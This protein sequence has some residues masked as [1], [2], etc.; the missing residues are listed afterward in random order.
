MLM[1]KD[2]CSARQ[3]MSHRLVDSHREAGGFGLPAHEAHPVAPE[4]SLAY[5]RGP[6][7]ADTSSQS[8][9]S[10]PAV[11]AE[12]RQCAQRPTAS[13]STMCSS[14]V[15]RRLKRR[16]GR[17]LRRLHWPFLALVRYFGGLWMTFNEELQ[18]QIYA[19]LQRTYICITYTTHRMI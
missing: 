8:P 4:E 2:S 6:G 19:C 9:L 15:Y 14:V 11:L 12:R 17:T 18:G 7:Q 1:S 10:A 16:L 5:P 3:F 13:S